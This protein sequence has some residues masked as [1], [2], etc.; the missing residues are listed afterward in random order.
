MRS[1]AWGI[2]IW[3]PK[4]E[5]DTEGRKGKGSTGTQLILEYYTFVLDENIYFIHKDYN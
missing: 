5:K 2:R 1:V 4:E 3:D